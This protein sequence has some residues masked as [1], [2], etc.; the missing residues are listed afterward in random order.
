[1][2]RIVLA[3]II[4]LAVL[5]GILYARRG[6]PVDD[7]TKP[8]ILTLSTG[9]GQGSLVH[10]ASV[11]VR[12]RVDGSALIS[13]STLQTQRVEGAFDIRYAGDYY[14]TDYTVR[15]LPLQVTSGWVRATVRFSTLR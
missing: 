12:G 15:Y 8:A 10:A 4:V 2:P 5:L 9:F 3:S 11:Q 1:M 14:S 6:L 7:V 13:G